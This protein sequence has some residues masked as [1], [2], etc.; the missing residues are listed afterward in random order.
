MLT[1]FSWVSVRR[2]LDIFTEKIIRH[3]IEVQ[4]VAGK[5]ISVVTDYFCLLYISFPLFSPLLL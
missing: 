3:G 5:V 1:H 4:R 2:A